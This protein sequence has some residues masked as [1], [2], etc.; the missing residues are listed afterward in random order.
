VKF[1]PPTHHRLIHAS[2]W[3][4]NLVGGR[5]EFTPPAYLDPDR[6]PRRNTLHYR[7]H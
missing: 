7:V 6:V 2:E 5:P 3:E 1:P 4:I